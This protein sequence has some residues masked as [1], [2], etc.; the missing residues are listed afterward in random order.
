MRLATGVG[1]AAT[2]LAAGLA[3][4]VYATVTHSRQA[5]LAASSVKARAAAAAVRANAGQPSADAAAAAAATSHSAAPKASH[6]GAQPASAA[7]S[8]AP[9]APAA[10]ATGNPD[11]HAFV[12]PAGRAVNTSHPA[13]VVGHGTPASCTSRALVR[14]VAQGGVITFAC[15]PNPVTITLAAT[16]KVRNTSRRVVIDGGGTVTLSGAGKRRILYLDTCDPKQ[17]WTTSHC[18]DQADPQLIVQNITFSGGNSTGQK[19]EG[20]GGGAIFDRGGRLKVVNSRFTGN[21][22]DRT[23]PDLGGAAIRA[24]SQYHNQPVY[25]VNDTFRRGVCSNGGALS[26]IGVSWQVLNTVMFSNRAIGLGANPAGNGTP[27]GGSGAAI[28]TDGDLYTVTVSGCLISGNSAK[29]GGGAIF[30]VSNNHSGTLHILHSRL[31][32]NPNA[33]FFTAGYP[34][35]FY[36]G[37]GTHPIVTDSTIN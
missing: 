24:L 10:P 16:A 17:T 34:G 20:G 5:P 25:I 15:G 23:G 13:H 26:S 11:G 9:A 3:V 6:H 35:I 12:P 30:Y 7:Q 31:H 22:C 21:R 1:L 14:A 28:Y 33:G 8:A 27:G 19:F 37:Q 32:H 18:Q 4:P 36:L 2:A 29:E